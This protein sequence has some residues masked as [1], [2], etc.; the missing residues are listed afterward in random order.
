LCNFAY[1]VISK[2]IASRIKDTLAKCIS[3]E[4][5]GFLKDRLIFD[6]VGITQECLHFAKLR[7]LNSVIL[8]LDLR[9]AYDN[10]SWQFLHLLFDHIGLDWNVTKWIMGC[11]TSVNTI[12]LVNGTPK[13]LWPVTDDLDLSW[14]NMYPMLINNVAQV[15]DPVHAKREFFQV[16]I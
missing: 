4:K 6:A 16:C 15:L 7:K 5:F 8:K 1:N 11:I 9:R 2:V 13:N 12:V 14:I 3:T 10:V